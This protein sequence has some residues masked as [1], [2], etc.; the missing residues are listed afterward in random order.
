MFTFFLV[1]FISKTENNYLCGKSIMGCL[2]YHDQ[3]Y[4]NTCQVACKGQR[5][6]QG[7]LICS[8]KNGFKY[9][10]SVTH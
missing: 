5:F 3:I 8:A 4:R 7:T 6:T 9:Q 1:M 2:T 10:I